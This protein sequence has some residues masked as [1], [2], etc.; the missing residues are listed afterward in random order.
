M[1]LRVAS[2]SDEISV[3]S[4]LLLVSMLGILVV[5]GGIMLRREQ[6]HVMICTPGLNSQSEHDIDAINIRIQFTP[7]Q[8]PVQRFQAPPRLDLGPAATAEVKKDI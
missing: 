4:A 1:S 6:A 8:R 7:Q 2:P 3:L 5:L